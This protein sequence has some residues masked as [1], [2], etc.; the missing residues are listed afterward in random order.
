MT[1]FF[2]KEQQLTSVR[3][4]SDANISGSY[5]NGSNGINA[6]LTISAS[7]L[8]ID[9]VVCAVGDRVLLSGQ[10]S[11]YQ[12]G[13]Y[14]VL[15][16]TNTVVLQRSSDFHDVSQIKPGYFVCVAAG[17]VYQ[18]NIFAV[19]EPQVQVVG[20]NNIVFD[21]TGESHVIFPVVDGDIPLFSGTEGL[22]KDSGVKFS[23][24]SDTVSPLFH[25]SATTGHFVTLN[26]TDKTIKDSGAAPSTSQPFV[27]M[28]PGSL[29][30]GNVAAFSDANGTLEDSGLNAVKVQLSSLSNPDN[31]S[32]VIWH[33]VN[34]TA[35]ALASGGSVVIQAS[36]GTKTYAVREIRVNQGTGLSGGGGDRLLKISD[37]FTSF[38]NAGITAALLGTPVN[39]LWGGIGNPL[40]SSVTFATPSAAGSNIVAIY[41]G[42]TTDYTTGNLTLSVLTQRL[43]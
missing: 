23:N 22:L 12:N 33:D 26:G 3:L 17:T 6:Q 19:V 41:N 8:T 9:S 31:I 18:S 28:S 36:S 14:D 25:G 1:Q 39:T 42:G 7:S 5:N 27:A 2:R 16:I 24:S 30:S 20:T 34:V 15:S 4:A 10:T 13:I 35:A 37:G 32:D 38:N 21:T 11:A 40:P 29:T 43:T